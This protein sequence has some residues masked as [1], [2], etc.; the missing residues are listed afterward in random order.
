MA[1]IT[2][3][4]RAIL[5]TPRIYDFFQCVMGARHGRQQLVE[6]FIR[7]QP[8][9]QILDI[10][11][12]TAE[13]LDFLP[14]DV[15]YIGYD[16][17]PN[18]TEAALKRFGDRGE[19]YCGFFDQNAAAGKPSFDV[20]LMLGALH[21]MDDEEVQHLLSLVSS[22][23]APNGRLVTIDPCFSDGQSPIARLLIS[24]DR[25]KNV[26]NGKAYESLVRS[27]FPKVKGTLRHRTWIPYTHWIME[28]SK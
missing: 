18:Y 25:G 10:G 7:P 2:H 21:H 28:C 17:S 23:L 16:I 3:G 9:E 14:H 5:S 15:Y 11:C 1:Q 12:G 27:V 19:F 26:R 6:E 4:I 24:R 8:G 20:V 13:I 22:V